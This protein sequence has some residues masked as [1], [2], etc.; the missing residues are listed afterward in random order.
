MTRRTQFG[1]I[2]LAAVTMAVVTLVP[3]STA[4]DASAAANL[5]TNGDVAPLTRVNP[6]YA[7]TCFTL[8]SGAPWYWAGADAYAGEWDS[9]DAVTPVFDMGQA[10]SGL[11]YSSDWGWTGDG[12]YIQLEVSS[13]G[14]SGWIEYSS[15]SYRYIRFW[16][17][18]DGND[19][20][21]HTW[22]HSA[23]ISA[24]S[25]DSP[26][27]TPTPTDTPTPTNTPTPT[28]T[29]T[30]TPTNTP[31]PTDTPTATNTPTNTATAANTAVPTAT[32]TPAVT[33][34]PEAT[35]TPVATSTAA[36][37]ATEA[38]SEPPV[39]GPPPESGIDPSNEGD[40][41]A[42]G[43]EARAQALPDTGSGD[44]ARGSNSTTALLIAIA[45]GAAG[46]SLFAAAARRKWT[47][48]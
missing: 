35:N 14:V 44:A 24:T 10:L 6:A 16:I 25:C 26:T 8:T 12:G 20:G 32:D 11:S 5:V 37:I 18:V 23:T 29:P 48:T 4:R 2:F 13:D 19:Y 45:L 47:E 1:A 28:D 33:D 9:A 7:V 36:A 39:A 41:A 34:T 42:G 15:G 31:T 22:I 30:D 21:G 43:A 17:Y 46:V 3:V 38:A 40:V 27:N